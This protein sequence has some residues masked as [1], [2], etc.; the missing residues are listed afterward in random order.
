MLFF[1]L[2]Y[3]GHFLTNFHF[4]KIILMVDGI[5]HFNSLIDFQM[6]ILKNGVRAL[7][8]FR[9]N[10]ATAQ[11]F[12]YSSHFAQL[13]T[14]IYFILHTFFTHFC[15]LESVL[16]KCMKAC[17]IVRKCQEFASVQINV[18][19]AKKSMKVCKMVK[20]CVQKF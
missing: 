20:K 8:H 17:I 3:K 18:K 13:H 14:F 7:V 9:A 19:C 1:T 2:T 10:C 5:V 15:T 4:F 11:L 6:E 12:N 16:K